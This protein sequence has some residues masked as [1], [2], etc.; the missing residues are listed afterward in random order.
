MSANE[1][2]K[3]WI[4]FMESATILSGTD[5]REVFFELVADTLTVLEK[6]MT[7]SYFE[8]LWCVE[9]VVPGETRHETAKRMITEYYVTTEEKGNC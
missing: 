9:E 3:K 5:D 6:D 7:D 2:K 8:L 1:L 4:E